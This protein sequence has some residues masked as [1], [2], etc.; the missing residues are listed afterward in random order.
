MFEYHS[1]QTHSEFFDGEGRTKVNEVRIRG[2]KGHK[3]V[4]IK[5]QAGRV[6]KRSKKALTKKQVKCI[7][8]CQFVPGLFKDCKVCF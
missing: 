7:Q 8:K 6:I 5:N 2:N 1:T 3:S 4:T